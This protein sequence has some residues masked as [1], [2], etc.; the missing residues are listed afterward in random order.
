MSFMPE[1]ALARLN[2]CVDENRLG[3]AYLIV[4]AIEPALQQV[5]HPWLERILGANPVKHPDVYRVHPQ[6]RLRQITLRDQ[7][8]PLIASLSQ[9]SFLG[10]WKAAVILEADR[11]IT[12]AANA[13][14]KTL[15]EPPPRTLI[16]LLSSFPERL[17]PTIRSRCLALRLRETEAP[18]PPSELEPVLAALVHRDRGDLVQAYHCLNLLIDYLDGVKRTLD[19]AATE[20]V[21]QAK[22][23]GLEGEGLEA[24]EKMR[25]AEAHTEYLTHRRD[26][27]AHMLRPLSREQADA[28]ALIENAYQE[29]NR[30][31]P[32]NLILE[33]LFLKLFAPAGCAP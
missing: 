10:G 29:F 19:S 31:L 33:R 8:R 1:E 4:G 26:A 13:F 11:L 18:A 20:Q 9:K 17:L 16:L 25:A 21:K 30:P 27:L 7:I 32:E 23:E 24:I 22:A 15:E 12:E 5:V 28:A 14:L 6:S 3:H 2:R